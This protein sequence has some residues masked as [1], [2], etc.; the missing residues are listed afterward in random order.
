[1]DGIRFESSDNYSWQA[2]TQLGL[3]LICDH[4]SARI[5]LEYGDLGMPAASRREH[6]CWDIG[7]GELALALGAALDAPVICAGWSRILIDCNRGWEDP[8]LILPISDGVVVPGNQALDEAECERRWQ[9][10]HQPYHGAI[11]RHLQGCQARGL[12]PLIIS[13]HS[14][15]P[16]FGGQQ[17]PWQVGVLWRP[18]DVRAAAALGWLT[19]AGLRVGDNEPYSGADLLGHSLERHALERGLP[20]LMFEVRQDLIDSAAGVQS[21]A[22]LLHDCVCAVRRTRDLTG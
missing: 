17:R 1:M 12:N 7:A 15:T 9:R 10:Y 3:L 16:V 8:T 13:I 2:G 22:N 5:P 6:I 4:A 19:A 20:Y 18:P 14:F 11:D 21:Y